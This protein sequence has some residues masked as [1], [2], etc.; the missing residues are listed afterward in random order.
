MIAEDVRRLHSVI[1]QRISL[2]QPSGLP[3]DVATGRVV[4]LVPSL[5]TAMVSIGGASTPVAVTYP[6]LPVAMEAGDRVVVLR[7]A[8]GWLVVSHVLGR[9][10]DTTV[11]RYVE[12]TNERF[13]S[14]LQDAVDLADA[15]GWGVWFPA[16]T[17]WSKP[18]T[19][20]DRMVLH[21]SPEATVKLI[22]G[23]DAPLITIPEGSERCAIAGFVMDGNRLNNSGTSH[24]IVT[25]AEVWLRD[26]ILQ[27]AVLDGIHLSGMARGSV[28]DNVLASQNGRDGFSIQTSDMH[29]TRGYA[30]RNGRYGYNL[31]SVL[32]TIHGGAAWWNLRGM[33]INGSVANG[34]SQQS[35]VVGIGIDRNMEAGLHIDT[36]V[37]G[38]SFLGCSFN[39]N[40]QVGFVPDTAYDRAP[41]YTTPTPG[42]HPNVRVQSTRGGLFF[43]GCQFADTAEIES[44]TILTALATSAAADDIIDTQTDHGFVAGD[45]V[46][47]KGGTRVG[48]SGLSDA[49]TYFVTD[50]GSLAARTCQLSSTQ[51]LALAG[52]S[53][54]G[55][56]TDI[57]A[58]SMAVFWRPSYDFELDPGAFVATAGN[59]HQ[60]HT[61][62]GLTNT[63]TGVRTTLGGQTFASSDGGI[64]F[65]AGST[66]VLY[67]GS[68]GLMRV[69]G[70]GTA[71]GGLE[72]SGQVK[73]SG[74]I[75]PTAL[76]ANAD[77]WSPSGLA[78]ASYIRATASTPVDITGIAGGAAGR[79]LV[80]HVA[81]GS[82][83][84]TLKHASGSSTATNRFI[85]PG[86]T[87]VV[88]SQRDTAVLRYDSVDQR[89]IVISHT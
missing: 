53:D 88:L 36:L 35:V 4:E 81:T 37:L 40:G 1:D 68:S 2:A 24:V 80:I 6:A 27:N 43:G 8:D 66:S 87:D 74:I 62:H 19:L 41:S 50:N 9:D 54:V 75:S 34:P 28:I 89:W 61:L 83:A 57:T 72:I 29:V 65:G 76:A 47:F 13:G 3:L 30:G 55:W 32:I 26:M 45:A 16:G 18:L 64:Y 7:R 31:A 44:A 77:D 49:A 59:Q 70:S 20:P 82:S 12:A 67:E 60:G 71:G 5:R 58:G 51:A 10:P 25:E 46:R 42:R 48:G 69:Y 39:A 56:T 79:F 33:Y 78:G 17:H 21:G 38:W 52:T 11:T 84:I 86:G 22:D 63:P 15:A 85:C 73:A 23:A 14:D